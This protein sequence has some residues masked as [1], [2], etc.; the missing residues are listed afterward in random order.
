MKKEYFIT[1]I[2]S[3]AIGAGMM[4]FALGGERSSGIEG[5]T[6]INEE[7]AASMRTL[8]T[9]AVE[10]EATGKK[11]AA[12]TGS[13]A[14]NK[15]E[16]KAVV[17]GVAD[18]LSDSAAK[19]TSAADMAVDGLIHINTAGLKELQEIPGIGEK[20]AQAILDYRNQNGAFSSIH[21][22]TKIKGIGEKMLEKMKPHIGL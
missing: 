22:L 18:D 15:T 16:D 13:A 7:V 1:S 9:S 10:T 8:S 19:T 20:K 2:V 17:S 12:E 5:W 11:L 21:D 14:A 3:A 6:A 4:L